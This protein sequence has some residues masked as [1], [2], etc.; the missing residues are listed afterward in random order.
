MD[1]MSIVFIIVAFCC[2]ISLFS[3]L[4]VTEK[5]IKLR[6]KSAELQVIND[7]LKKENDRKGS[8]YSQDILQY[9]KMFTI[10]ITLLRFREYADTHHIEK[11]TKENT[12]NLIEEI[13]NEVNE[14]INLTQINFEEMLFTEQF[15]EKFIVSTAID[16]VKKLLSDEVDKI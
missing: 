15:V 12:K 1:K 8:K 16:T 6:I 5:Y 14:S 13:S 9:V 11:T 4:C 3:M 7:Q 10:Q 2:V